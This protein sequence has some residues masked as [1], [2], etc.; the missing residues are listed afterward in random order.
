[1]A[2][3]RRDSPDTFL[4]VLAG[5]S[6]P[7]GRSRTKG[8]REK[9]FAAGGLVMKVRRLLVVVVLGVALLAGCGMMEG[10][11][12]MVAQESRSI[13]GLAGRTPLRWWPMTLWRGEQPTTVSLAFLPPRTS[14]A[15]RRT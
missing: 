15:S 2:G 5:S 7:L 11:K 13:S 6:F 12:P 8:W 3:S 1:G 4:E 10:Q 9:H 14:H